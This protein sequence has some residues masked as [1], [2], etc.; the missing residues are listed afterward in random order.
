MWTESDQAASNAA[1]DNDLTSVKPNPPNS[2][3][4][5]A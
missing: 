1:D 3:F 4:I 5:L 2:T